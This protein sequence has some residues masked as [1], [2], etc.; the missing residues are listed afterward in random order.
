MAKLA[1]TTK[2]RERIADLTD[3]FAIKNFVLNDKALIPLDHSLDEPLIFNGFILTICLKGNAKM[4]LNYQDHYVDEGCIFTYLPNQI[5][6]L[7]ERSENLIIENLFLSADYILQ[8]PLP[9]DFEL[10]KK[11][12]TKP[13][14]KINR[15]RYTI[16]WNCT[17]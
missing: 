8:L 11:I 4:R 2:Y 9:K 3:H 13:V 7:L 10:L 5:L 6:K 1:D 16:C 12:A 14:Q 17:P 15:T